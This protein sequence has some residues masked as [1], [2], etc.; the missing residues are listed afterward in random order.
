[1]EAAGGFL[2]LIGLVLIVVGLVR[3]MLPGL[4]DKRK[5]SRY[6]LFGG[7]AAFVVAVVIIPPPTP[8]QRAA[9]A[10]AEAREKARADKAQAAEKAAAATAAA[11]D[12]ERLTGEV[13][14]LWSAIVAA[15]QPC[16]SASEII[17]AALKSGSMF[18]L[19]EASTRGVAACREAS[20]DIGGLDAPASADGDLENAF[21]QAIDKCST[22]QVSKQI[23]FEQLAEVANGDQRPSAIVEAREK[24]TSAGSGGLYCAAAFIETAGKAGIE[25]KA[26]DLK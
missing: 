10:K 7:F 22:S 15:A 8:E 2:G 26:L 14:R 24:M 21:E 13:R 16:D 18:N 25:P 20:M 4:K 17:G 12:K 5:Q 6:I 3:L 19:Y 11:T 9:A 1:M 23:A